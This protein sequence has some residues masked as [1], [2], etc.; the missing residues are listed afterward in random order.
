[1]Y[2]GEKLVT[3]HESTCNSGIKG[4]RGLVLLTLYFPR[5]STVQDNTASLPTGVVRLPIGSPNSGSSGTSLVVLHG[6]ETEIEAILVTTAC[7]QEAPSD[8]SRVIHGLMTVSEWM[9]FSLSI[10]PHKGQV[11]VNELVAILWKIIHNEML[12]IYIMRIN[13]KDLTKFALQS[14]I[15]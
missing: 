1:M 13:V 10:I 9:V 5:W 6:S 4:V 2:M 7:L 12:I 8:T 11:L 15:T 14:L 3:N